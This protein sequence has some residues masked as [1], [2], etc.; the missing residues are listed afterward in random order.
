MKKNKHENH[1]YK[2][3]LVEDGYI[4]EKFSD[5]GKLVLYNYTDKCTFDKKWN[6]HT[7]NSRGHVYQVNPRKLV[8]RA[9]PKFFNL[10]ELAVSKQRNLLKKTDYTITEKLD[11]SLGICFYYDG[12][13]RV[14]TRGS[15]N[16]EQAQEARKIIEEK[17]KLDFT[18]NSKDI[19]ILVEIIY[20]EN[21][22]IIN[23]ED[24]RELIILSAYITSTGVELRR[25]QLELLSTFSGMPL[26]EEYKLTFDEMFEFQK[27]QNLTIEGYVVRFANGERVKIKS[28]RYLAI[29]RVLSNL[30]PL[31]LWKTMKGGIVSQEALEIV[32]EEFRQEI[33]QITKNLELQYEMIKKEIYLKYDK[34]KNESR[35]DIGQSKIRHKSGVFF[36]ID[37]KLAK[38]DNYIMKQIRPK[39]D[40]NGEI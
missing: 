28:K 11:G 19:T 14:N 27:Q 33:N 25:D 5:D 20:P 8:A 29:A 39:G 21:Q 34:L 38:L 9:F 18:M 6:Y 17:Y 22:I 26:V 36:M 3:Q 4:A 2:H 35:K 1:F 40:E 24:R 10:G 23:Y 16:S 31:S 15:F 13:W 12:E 37:N 32:P 30:T 7:K